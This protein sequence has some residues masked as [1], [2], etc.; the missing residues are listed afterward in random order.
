MQLRG[1]FGETFVADVIR[2]IH[3]QALSGVLRLNQGKVL[4]AIFFEKGLPVFAI[5]NLKSEQIGEALIRFQ[6]ILPQN[7][8][9]ALKFQGTRERLGQT[10]I[11]L[12][13]LTPEKLQHG[14]RQNMSDIICS[15]FEWTNG[16]YS[17]DE[18]AR[19]E[20]DVKLNVLTADII[21]EGA[22]R[23]RDVKF[24]RNAIY[25]LKRKVRIGNINE[26]DQ[27]GIHMQPHEA[28]VLSR[29]DIPTSVDDLL[30]ICGLAEEKAL[31][32]IYGLVAA[33][34]LEIDPLA[35]ARK[36][37]AQA[38]E[39]SKEITKADDDEVSRKKI[40][41]E[42]TR[43]FSFYSTADHFEVLGVTRTAD[44]E[45]IKQAYYKLAKKF[46]PDRY[47]HIEDADLTDRLDK[48]LLRLSEA[49]ESLK[50]EPARKA[51]LR[52]IGGAENQLESEKEA[53]REERP[54]ETRRNAERAA[55]GAAKPSSLTSEADQAQFNFDRGVVFLNS[56]DYGKAADM[57]REAVR[58]SPNNIQYRLQLATALANNPRWHPE[59]EEQFRKIIEIDSFND[60]YYTKWGIFYQKT[61]QPEKAREK[62]EEALSINPASR[63]ALRMLG[64]DEAEEKAAK[65]GFLKPDGGSLFSRFLRRG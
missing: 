21:L 34:I 65:K 64:R 11:R 32:A 23:I 63:T 35:C 18:L 33:G 7:L 9:D 61:N 2:E 13:Y 1:K 14:L 29:A 27:R 31:R 8:Q 36:Q 49:Y 28:Y 40:R 56:G 26:L 43:T 22:R 50:E 16:E 19:A 38:G 62:F 30:K 42:V 24:V 17:F 45:A 10:L 55:E 53:A 51:Y 6:A 25:D 20:H 15:V 12:K 58:L 5:S 37:Q 47:R 54:A 46:H 57:L 39:D 4:K 3:T 59:A 52:S 48:I 44:S 60:T 41:E